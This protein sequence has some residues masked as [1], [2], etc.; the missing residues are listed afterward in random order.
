MPE[1]AVYSAQ[2]GSQLPRAATSSAA[3]LPAGPRAA[4][5]QVHSLLVSESL[6]MAC[7]MVQ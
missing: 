3:Q 1:P 5:G 6:H 4:G 7:C 2:C